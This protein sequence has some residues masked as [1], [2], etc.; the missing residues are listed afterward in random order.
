M[1]HLKL[2]LN[3]L[4]NIKKCKKMI[5]LKNKNIFNL[6]LLNLVKKLITDF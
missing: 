4:Q 1:I 2:H 3:D 6:Y 5:T